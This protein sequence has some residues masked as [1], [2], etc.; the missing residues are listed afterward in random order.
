MARFILTLIILAVI[1]GA[2]SY[3]GNQLGR[4]IGRKKMSIFNLRP[5]HTSILIT[6]VTGS[7]IAVMTLVFSYITSWEVRT[8][9]EGLKTFQEKISIMTAKAIEQEQT[10]GVLYRPGEPLLTAVVDGTQSREDIRAQLETIMSYV[11]E[12]A[13]QKNK[14]VAETMKT[15]FVIPQ[16]GKIAGYHKS[17]FTALIEAIEKIKGKVIVKPVTN[18]YAFLGER[19][20][21]NFNVSEY[22]SKVFDQDSVVTTGIIDGSKSNEDIATNVSKL[23]VQ[24]KITALRKGM[25][26]NPITYKLIEIDR[27]DLINA[28]NTISSAKRPCTAIVKA[29]KATDNRGPLEVYLQIEPSALVP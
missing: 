8:L 14:D 19:F 3:L 13:I 28:M 29:K 15:T 7:L 11:N 18:S 23:M 1:G 17:E 21:V 9:F 6:T 10:G 16:D 27:N 26:E 2:V 22:I 12:A 24:A 25:L 20:S 4:Y 5:R